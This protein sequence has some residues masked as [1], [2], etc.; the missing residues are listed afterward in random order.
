MKG[1]VKDRVLSV[2]RGSGRQGT[3]HANTLTI[4]FQIVN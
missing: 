4:F 3:S 2:N 1:R